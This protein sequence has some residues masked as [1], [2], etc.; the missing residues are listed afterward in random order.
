MPKRCALYDD[1]NVRKF[2]SEQF[3]V[4]G[5]QSSQEPNNSFSDPRNGHYSKIE[6]ISL[7]SNSS[8]QS[9]SLHNIAEMSLFIKE[10]TSKVFL[11]IHDQGACLVLHST[12]VTYNV[13]P[14]KT[15]PDTLVL[16]PETIAPVN[17]SKIVKVM[18]KCASNS[19]PTAPELG[20]N[21]GSTGEWVREDDSTGECLCTAGWEKVS[22]ECKGMLLLCLITISK[23][24]IVYNIT[25]VN[26]SCNRKLFGYLQCTF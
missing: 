3:D 15:L 5:Y 18:G 6:T 11:A 19:K 12:V 8:N 7:Q 20:A 13:C 2:C 4:Y 24:L 23:L 22:S 10:R 14:E 25:L 21:C 16:L 9:V 1:A 17:E 26:N